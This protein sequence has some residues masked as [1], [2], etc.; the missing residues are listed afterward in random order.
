MPTSLKVP[1]L[2]H[3]S[4]ILVETHWSKYRFLAAWLQD[5]ASKIV[6]F[7]QQGPRAVFILSANG[8][9]SSATLRHPATSGGSVTYEVLLFFLYCLTD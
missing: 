6:S 8:T 9:V 1:L 5:V 4:S 3:K 7:S 2:I